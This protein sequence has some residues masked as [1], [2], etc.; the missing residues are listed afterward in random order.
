MYSHQVAEHILKQY[1]IE[2]APVD[3]EKLAWLLGAE[4]VRT[5]AEGGQSG[6]VLR[7][8]SRVV[9]GV[10]NGT[11]RRRQRFTIAHE[12]GH[13]Q[14]HSGNL[15]VDSSIRVNYRDDVSSMATDEEEMQANKFAAALLMPKAWVQEAVV[16]L[17]A[18]ATTREDL[19][20]RLAREF[21][22]STEAMGYR[23]INLGIASA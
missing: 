6:F 10:N 5:R 13:L 19:I 23:L 12:I 21:D 15:I 7:D 11:S 1:G 3:V 22:V 4:L 16:R 17:S 18:S 14:L 20:S 8:G 2:S 9:I